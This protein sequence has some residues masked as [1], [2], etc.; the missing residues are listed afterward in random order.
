MKKMLVISQLPIWDIQKNS[1]KEVMNRTFYAFSSFYDLEIIAPGAEVS[2]RNSK[3]YKINNSIQKRLGTIKYLGHLYNY[4]YVIIFYLKVKRIIKKNNIKPD[5]VYLIG[6][7]SSF[8]GYKLFKNR[9]LIVNRYYGVAWNEDKFNTIRERL[10]FLIKNYCYKHFGDFAIMTNDGTKGDKFLEKIGY[11]K[12]KI[13]FL[14]NGIET[15]FEVDHQLKT[16]FLEKHKIPENSLLFLTVSRLASWKRVEKA[17]LL[18]AELNKIHENVYLIIIG[19]GEERHNLENLAKKTGIDEI[20]IFTGAVSRE[21]L[22]TYYDL[23]GFFLSFY[24]FSNAGNPLFEAMLHGKCII[25]LN[26]GDTGKFID[27]QSAVLL[28][29]ENQETIL[30]RTLEIMNNSTRKKKISQDAKKTLRKN[31]QSWNERIDY[32]IDLIEKFSK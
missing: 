16:S 10:K 28:D 15:S 30:E 6:Y 8:V 22:P 7:W 4:L 24:E 2:F 9:A 13:F 29:E 14:K 21:K 11:P 17:I 18:I 12:E 23:A 3:F 5:V 32:E 1:G 25:T 19:D 31:F 26:N 27:D 20:V